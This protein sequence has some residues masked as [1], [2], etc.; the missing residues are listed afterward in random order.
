MKNLCLFERFSKI[1]LGVVF[2]LISVGFMLSGVTVLP[3]FGF[4]IALPFFLVSLYFFN[5]HMNKACQIK[6]ATE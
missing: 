5:A 4:V 2:L 1:G 6:E 3:I